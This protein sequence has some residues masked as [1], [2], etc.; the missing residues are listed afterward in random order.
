MVLSYAA[1]KC[2]LFNISLANKDDFEA[3]MLQHV[4]L[5]VRRSLGWVLEFE[6][7]DQAHSFGFQGG[8]FSLDV[9]NFGFG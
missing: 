4:V 1:A 7:D 6:I 5:C 8:P 2:D 9:R 3:F